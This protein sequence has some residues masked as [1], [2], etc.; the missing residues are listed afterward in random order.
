MIKSLYNNQNDI[1]S[2]IIK[3]HCPDGFEC[4]P[5][6]GNG[7]FYKLIEKPKNCFDIDPQFDF[8]VKASSSNLP[9]LDRSIKN[10]IIDPPFLTYV[11][12]GRKHKS[13]KVALTKRFGGYYSYSDLEKHYTETIQES[14]RV[15]D[16]KGIMVF[17]CQDII[18]NHKIHATHVNVIKWAEDRGFRLLDLFILSANHRMPGPQIGIQRHAR[19]FHSYF[20]VFKKI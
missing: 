17:K 20:L 4:D 12:D 13:G 9:L 5:T 11:K 19:I 15:L 18:H 16:K 3:L 6:F 10:I 14:S 8:V 7:V 2:S 1:L